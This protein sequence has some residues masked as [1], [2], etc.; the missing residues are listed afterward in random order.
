MRPKA[1]WR[2]ARSTAH[3][4]G[5]RYPPPLRRLNPHYS[6]A[7]APRANS[8]KPSTWHVTERLLNGPDGPDDDLHSR[9][10]DSGSEIARARVNKSAGTKTCPRTFLVV[11][12]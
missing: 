6:M 5:D 8:T 10:C 9:T 11:V 1:P 7:G 3:R 2:E 4:T 12:A